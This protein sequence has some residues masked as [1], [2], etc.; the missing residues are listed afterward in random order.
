MTSPTAAYAAENLTIKPDVVARAVGDEM[1]L[2]DLETGTY[3]TLNAIGAI[4][5]RGLET[6]VSFEAMATA[7]VENYEVDAVT[8][9]SDIDEYVAQLIAEGLVT[10]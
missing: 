4:V 7:I 2:L 3:F 8:A 1:I 9:L 6:S 10:A 5:W